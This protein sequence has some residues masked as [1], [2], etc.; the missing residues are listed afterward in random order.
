MYAR[1][2]GE[3]PNTFGAPNTWPGHRIGSLDAKDWSYQGRQDW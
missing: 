3:W 1:L 2:F